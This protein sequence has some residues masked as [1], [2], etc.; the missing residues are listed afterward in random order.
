MGTLVGQ[1]P[2]VERTSIEAPPN[3]GRFPAGFVVALA[4][5]LATAA[6]NTT[7]QPTASTMRGPTVAFESIDGPSESVFQKL[8]QNLTEQATIRQLAVVSRE[9]SAQYRVRGYVAAQTQGKRSTV[10]WVWDVY[11]TEQRRALRISGEEPAS[12]LGRGTWAVAD[13][14]VLKRIAQVGMDRLVAFVASPETRPSTVPPRIS[15][16]ATV[17]A[18]RS[19]DAAPETPGIVRAAAYQPTDDAAGR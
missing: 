4:L 3:R 1:R 5:G 13:D 11:D 7:G 19:G 8:V 17:V 12:T 10:A 15:A 14:V 2:G 18:A 6:C 16:P 9:S